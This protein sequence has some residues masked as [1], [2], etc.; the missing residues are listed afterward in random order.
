M[1]KL[2]GGIILSLLMAVP[3][4]A[5]VDLNTATQAEL[6]A[7]KGIGPNKAKSII[8]HRDKYGPFKSVEELAKVKGFGKASVTKLKNE[9]SVGT[10]K[11][12]ESAAKPGK[13]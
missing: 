4:F 11:P 6:E 3:A 7:V 2:I 10:G 8:D 12:A 13:S 1:K 5:V 9:F